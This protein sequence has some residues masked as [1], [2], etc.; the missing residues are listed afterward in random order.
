M[1]SRGCQSESVQKIWKSKLT[2]HFDKIGKPLESGKIKYKTKET[3]KG[4][5]QSKV[6]VPGLGYAQGDVQRSKS[7]AEHDAARKALNELD[8]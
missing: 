5:F 4:G 8:Q 2:E 6:F 1:A 7:E 3:P